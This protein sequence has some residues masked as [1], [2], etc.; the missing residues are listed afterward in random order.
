MD[1][2]LLLRN[3]VWGLGLHTN[4]RSI[5]LHVILCQMAFHDMAN[6][7]SFN[8]QVDIKLSLVGFW[9]EILKHLRS[10]GSFSICD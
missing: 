9:L 1:E 5:N 4:I 2:T 6:C 10:S 3:K 7:F 8:E